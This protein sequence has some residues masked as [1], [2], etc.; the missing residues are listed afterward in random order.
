M[1]L[2]KKQEAKSISNWCEAKK[3][4]FYDKRKTWQVKVNTDSHCVS[5][6]EERKKK[7]IPLVVLQAAEQNPPLLRR[8]QLDHLFDNLYSKIHPAL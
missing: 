8:Q 5:I 2:K 3:N 6:S 7:K 1:N 4:C